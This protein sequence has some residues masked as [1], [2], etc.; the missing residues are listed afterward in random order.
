MDLGGCLAYW[1]Q[2]D[3]EE[4]YR[5]LRRQPSDKPG[6]LTRAEIISYYGDRTGRQ[7]GPEQWLF[8]EVFGLFRLAV[9]LQQVYYRYHHGQTHN[10]AFKDL[11][12]LVGVLHD[13]ASALVFGRLGG[14]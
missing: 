4:P 7:V 13:R 6:M 11:H 1:I 8:Y 14:G 2:A 12:Q 9:I 5:S 10:P 3:D